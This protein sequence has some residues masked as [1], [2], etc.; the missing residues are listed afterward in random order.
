MCSNIHSNRANE[1]EFSELLYFFVRLLDIEQIKLL[2]KSFTISF[3]LLFSISKQT[4]FSIEYFN[5]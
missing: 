4:F 3:Y 2:E 1:L 5:F